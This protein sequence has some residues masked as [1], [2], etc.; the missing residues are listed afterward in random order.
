MGHEASGVVHAV[1]SEVE[2]LTP[3]MNVAVEPSSPCRTCEHCKRGSYNLCAGMKFAACPPDT[4]GCLTRFYKMPA[5]FAYAL[6]PNVELQEGVL[7]EPLAVGAHAARMIDVKPGQSIVI[8][9]AGTVG[10]CAAVVSQWY[11]AKKVVL[12]DVQEQKLAFAKGI[13]RDC[14]TIRPDGKQR[15]EQLAGTIIDSCKLGEGADA[16]IEATGAEPCIQ[17]GIHVLRKGGQYVQTGLGKTMIP[18]P[19]VTV[20]EKELHMHGA[21][22]YG[23]EDFRVAL[24]VL[25]SGRWD[26]KSLISRVFDMTETTEAWDATKN[27][28]GIKNMIRV[29][30]EEVRDT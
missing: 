14:V 13:L 30:G 2:S 3:G 26:F 29:G 7:A 23:P 16:V 18:F 1:G 28:N 22:R 5:D 15:A 27:G 11:G 12:V 4:H 20:S 21:F 24:D 19:I 10:L 17:A 8:M 25:E 6:P 9:G